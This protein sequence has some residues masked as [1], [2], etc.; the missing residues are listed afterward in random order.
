MAVLI[1][2]PAPPLPHPGLLSAAVG[3]LPMPAHASVD[4]VQYILDSCGDIQLYP[5]ACDLTPPTKTFEGSD[6][7]LV[8]EPFVVIASS[9]CGTVGQSLSEVEGRVRRRLQLKEGWGVERAFWGGTTDVPG[10]LQSHAVT[11]LTATAT[12]G[13]TAALSRLEQALAD[14][15]G[16]PGLIH[17]RPKMAAYLGNAG[18][19]RLEGGTAKTLRG[20]TVVFGDGYSGEGPAGEDAAADG[21]TEWMYASGRVVVWRD[22]EAFVP[23]LRQVLDRTKNQQYALAE[24]TY[25]LGVECFIATTLVTVGDPV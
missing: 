24:R 6:G 25:A 11:T 17:V 9:V 4:G 5:G 14:S 13:V 15:Y 16:L 18:L 2:P 8:A 23:P 20:N 22:S 10:Y 12:G 19:I 21:T 7:T 1:E 3:P